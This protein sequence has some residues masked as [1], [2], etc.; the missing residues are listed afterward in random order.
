MSIHYKNQSSTAQSTRTR[1]P[2]TAVSVQSA[3]IHIP[4]C[5]RRCYYC[6]FPVKVMGDRSRG[7]TSPTIAAYVRVLCDEIL[8]T[9]NFGQPLRTIFLGGGTPS[10]LSAQQVETILGVLDR[11]MGIGSEAEISIEI[12]PDACDRKQLQDLVSL[13][14]NRISLGVQAFQDDLL[15][16]LGRTHCR[17][18]IEQVVNWLHQIQMENYSFDLIS[19]LP[20]QTLTDWH[21]SLEAAIALEPTHL[22]CYDLILEPGTPFERQSRLG[23]LTMPADELCAD[24][25]RNAH[26]ILTAHGFEHYEISNYARSGFQC[27]HNRVYWERGNFYGFGMGAA[28]YLAGV[29]FTRPRTTTAYRQW[30]D[31]EECAISSDF[32]NPIG[33][34]EALGEALMLGLRLAEGLQWQHLSAEFGQDCLDPLWRSIQQFQRQGWVVFSSSDN[35]N[36]I[37]ATPQALSANAFLRITN[38][39]G[40]LV[41]NLVLSTFFNDLDLTN[42]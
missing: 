6:D 14:I 16:R 23:S 24:L 37:V 41:S 27:R 38:P 39:D 15:A 26:Q 34:K 40:F 36:L 4:F 1:H 22:S 5:R 31:D 20:G 10:L 18:D 13:G 11:Q 21:A 25:Y 33:P 19:G 30:V 42:D 9:P 29:R 17:N 28:S 3:Y 12:D 2:L 35:P 7:D 8:K 32:A